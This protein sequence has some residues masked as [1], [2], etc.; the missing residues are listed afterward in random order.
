MAITGCRADSNLDLELVHLD[1]Q[2]VMPHPLF[3]YFFFTSPETY[4][5][6]GVIAIV[7]VLTHVPGVLT[8]FIQKNLASIRNLDLMLYGQGWSLSRIFNGTNPG[9]I[10]PSTLSKQQISLIETLQSKLS[11]MNGLMMRSRAEVIAMPEYQ[12]GERHECAMAVR[13]RQN[14]RLIDAQI[15]VAN[16]TREFVRGRSA[17]GDVYQP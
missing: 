3:Q 7:G 8:F 10:S 5:V 14:E 11:A 4:D 9:Y 16:A 13:Q 2:S 15:G 6:R 17:G 1:M 12:E